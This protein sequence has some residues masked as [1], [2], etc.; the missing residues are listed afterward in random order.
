MVIFDLSMLTVAAEGRSAWN[1]TKLASRM[2]AGIV[3]QIK[4]GKQC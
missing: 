3:V 1:A 2:E 4:A